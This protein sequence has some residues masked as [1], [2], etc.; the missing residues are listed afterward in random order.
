MNKDRYFIGLTAILGTLI[1]LST[2]FGVGIGTFFTFHKNEITNAN[3]SFKLTIGSRIQSIRDTISGTIR[4]VRTI[5]ALF[6]VTVDSIHPYDQFIPFMDR[7]QINI[8]GVFSLGWI[9]RVSNGDKDQFIS[10]V[11]EF[12]RDYQSFNITRRN[13]QGILVPVLDTSDYYYPMYYVS[14]MKPNLAAIG[15]DISTEPIRKNALDRS[16]ASNDDAVTSRIFLPHIKFQQPGVLYLSPQIRGLSV[17]VFIIGDLMSSVSSRLDGILVSIF[18]MGMYTDI[19]SDKAISLDGWNHK[20][21]TSTQFLWSNSG[22]YGP[23]FGA[24]KHIARIRDSSNEASFKYRYSILVGDRQWDIL[25]IPEYT[26]IKGY[27]TGNKWISLVCCILGS[28]IFCILIWVLLG[29]LIIRWKSKDNMHLFEI[30]LI[31]KASDNYKRLLNYMGKMEEAK[32]CMLDAIPDMLTVIN[33][34]GK[35]IH[36]NAMFNSL[37][38]YSASEYK[39]GIYIKSIFDNIQL[40]LLTQPNMPI[41]TDSYIKIKGRESIPVTYS[42]TQLD[43]DENS[44]LPDNTMNIDSESTNKVYVFIIRDMRNNKALLSELV[45]NKNTVEMLLKTSDFERRWETDTVFCQQILSFCIKD[46]SD[47]NILFL[48]DTDKF[49]L[50]ATLD[51]RIHEQEKIINTYLHNLS[52]KQLN[53]NIDLVNDIIETARFRLGDI[54]VFDRAIKLIKITLITDIYPRY[55][56]EEVRRISKDR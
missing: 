21:Y 13:Q 15:F 17:G 14:P 34:E 3:N 33:L 42:Y 31:T 24:D 10:K 46:R 35:I 32:K 23:T 8:D 44:F 52:P 36:T 38:N 26:Y 54:H 41:F 20:N 27:R 4:S 37:Y 11:R 18:D 40:D 22:E 25:F 2:G 45:G 56:N 53:L 50:L 39:E 28:F 9:D 43:I 30:E 47:E 1:I 49:K 7:S 6:N 5:S 51:A 48:Q 29:Y 16:L 19:P 12:G 55:R